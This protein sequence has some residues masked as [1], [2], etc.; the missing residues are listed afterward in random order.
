MKVFLKVFLKEKFPQIFSIGI[1]LI[2]GVVD[3][4]DRISGSHDPE[5]PP[6]RLMFDGSRSI[7]EFKKNGEDFLNYLKE[8][9]DLKPDAQVLDVGCGIGR[10]TIP[11]TKYLN[12]N[13]RYEG[14]DI[15]GIGIEWCKKNITPKYPNFNF[16][17][18]DV[19]NKYYNP[20]AE[21]LAEEFKFPYPDETFDLVFLGSVFTHMMP[22]EVDNYLSEIS[23]T[24]KP[25]G[26][27]FISFFLSNEEILQLMES[28]KSDI[29]FKYEMDNYRTTNLRIPEDVVCYDESFIRKL[30]QKN[31]FKVIEPIYYGSW[32]GIDDYLDYQ[33]IILAVKKNR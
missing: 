29:D 32:S 23:R 10:K 14:F 31:G 1:N 12:E 18:V 24:L 25:N 9:C 26:K 27:S 13:G 8:I 19:Y 4:L 15:T 28:R 30:Y 33:D 6:T 20:T 7:M 17:R 5:I 3:I 21:I 22:E 16:N 2:Y 11:L